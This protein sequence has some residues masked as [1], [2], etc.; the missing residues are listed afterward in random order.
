MGG[1]RKKQIIES[2]IEGEGEGVNEVEVEV[3]VED[4]D[5]GGS[6]LRYSETEKV[7]KHNFYI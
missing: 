7:R 4:E 2:E 6:Q 3:E 5:D 1:K